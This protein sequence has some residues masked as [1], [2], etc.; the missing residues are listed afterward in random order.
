M[1]IFEYQC[2]SCESEFELLIRSRESQPACPDCGSDE[3][4][5]LISA[6]SAHVSTGGLPI[7]S[8][9]PPSDAPPCGPGCCRR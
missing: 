2:Q 3:L 6:P 8:S 7:A 5:K 9:C 4:D 1:P